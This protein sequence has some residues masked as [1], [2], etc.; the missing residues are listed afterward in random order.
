MAL[1]RNKVHVTEVT[2]WLSSFTNSSRWHDCHP[3]DKN[4]LPLQES[5]ALTYILQSV[6]SVNTSQCL[7]KQCNHFKWRSGLV[8]VI[9]CVIV[10]LQPIDPTLWS[11]GV[12]SSR[13]SPEKLRGK[14]WAQKQTSSSTELINYWHDLLDEFGALSHF[15]FKAIRANPHCPAVYLA[16]CV[17]WD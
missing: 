2:Q 13:W 17:C 1:V 6:V 3:A 5:I 16:L 8:R 7:W 9:A 14:Y 15:I 12:T 4:K 10:V 11:C